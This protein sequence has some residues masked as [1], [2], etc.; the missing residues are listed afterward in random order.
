MKPCS[1]EVKGADMQTNGAEGTTALCLLWEKAH[2]LLYTPV[3]RSRQTSLNVSQ[4]VE[5]QYRK[6][7]HKT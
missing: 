6:S 4:Q 1:P 2:M 7:P 3:T 5:E